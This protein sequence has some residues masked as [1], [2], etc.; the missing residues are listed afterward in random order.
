[1]ARFIPENRNTLLTLNPIPG[2][3]SCW[4]LAQQNKYRLTNY[5]SGMQCTTVTFRLICIINL[6]M[7]LS[8]EIAFWWSSGYFLPKSK[9]I[10]VPDFTTTITSIVADL[11]TGHYVLGNSH[12]QNWTYHWSMK[13]FQMYSQTSS[14]Q[15]KHRPKNNKVT[16]RAINDHSYFHA[17]HEYRLKSSQYNQ[18][19]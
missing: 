13:L 15:W 6:S 18:E 4:D 11:P 3:S 5:S 1:M 12:V 16:T 17:T 14:W 9:S 2:E 7:F 10:C 19:C 8:L